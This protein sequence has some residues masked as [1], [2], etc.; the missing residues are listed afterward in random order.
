M[1]MPRKKIMRNKEKMRSIVRE[2]RNGREKRSRIPRQNS[3]ETSVSQQAL[4]K[5]H[6]SCFQKLCRFEFGRYVKKLSYSTMKLRCHFLTG[7]L[8]HLTFLSSPRSQNTNGDETLLQRLHQCTL[9][10][11]YPS[12]H[13]VLYVLLVPNETCL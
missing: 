12:Y 11:L 9:I 10:C 13:A 5:T 8:S 7:T 6:D 1:M 4:F 3:N 2:V